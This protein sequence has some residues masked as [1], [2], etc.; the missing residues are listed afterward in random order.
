MLA[1]VAEL[2]AETIRERVRAGL[3]A[4][5]RRGVAFGPVRKVTRAKL[6]AAKRLLRGDRDASVTSIARTLA[7]GRS[8]SRAL[9]I[10]KK[11][12]RAVGRA[13][14]LAGHVQTEKACAIVAQAF[15]KLTSGS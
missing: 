1:A 5:C 13:S 11:V 15:R 10:P 9:Q 4:A 14:K 12:T 7:V 6:S 3:D 2:E 8:S